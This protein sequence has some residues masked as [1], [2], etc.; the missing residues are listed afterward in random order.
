MNCMKSFPV[1]DHR[2]A[3]VLGAVLIAASISWYQIIS[4]MAPIGPENLNAIRQGAF[5]TLSLV[6]VG[7]AA[8]LSGATLFLRTNRSKQSSET[9]PSSAALSQAL[10]DKKSFRIFGLSALIYGMFFSVVSSIAVYRPGGVTIAGGLL[11]PPSVAS[12]VCCGPLGQM[13]QFVVYLSQQIA[14]LIIPVNLV[15]LAGSSWLVGLNAAI[16]SY[17][18]NSGRMRVN[19][20]LIGGLGGIVALFTACPT[21]AG[22]FLLSV[23]GLAGAVP[24]ALTMASSQALFVLA[25]FPILLLTPLLSARRISREPILACPVP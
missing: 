4:T 17:S 2:L 8:S 24:L 15:L 14:L 21:C 10:K 25:G 11:A 12:V 7:L 16:A 23:L 13:P 9:S 19:R 22:F 20:S 3:I 1:L 18:Y 5:A 6:I